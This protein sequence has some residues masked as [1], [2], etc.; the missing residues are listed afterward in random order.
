MLSDQRSPYVGRFAR[1]WHRLPGGRLPGNHR[2]RLEP[3]RI[4]ATS[5]HRPPERPR[6]REDTDLRGACPAKDRRALGGGR[7][8]RQDVVD[9]DDP[10]GRYADGAERAVERKAPGG[11]GAT[12]LR[13][14]LDRAR[15]EL[16][17]GKAAQS[18]DDPGKSFGLVVATLAPAPAPE[19]HPCEN[20]DGRI[21]RNDHRGRALKRLQH[22]RSQGIRDRLLPS[23][24]EPHQSPPHRPL[25][26]ESRSS[27]G[28][29]SWRAVVAPPHARF[30][31]TAAG[32]ATGRQQVAHLREAST[33][34]GPRPC[35][36][37]ETASWKQKVEQCQ[38]HPG[39]VVGASDRA[40]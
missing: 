32:Q 24:L 13:A 3:L 29:R 39:R 12:G 9:Q 2:P 30:E 4:I 31:R 26:E 18:G 1:D 23:E 37:A 15:Q 5:R 14:R 27:P 7:P 6:R 17:D 22:E 10:S 20:R 33:A 11:A 28:D 40:L 21:L 36:A 38:A 35:A 16:P 25:V 34:E 19:R 8:A